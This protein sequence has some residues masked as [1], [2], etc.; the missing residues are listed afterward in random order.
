MTQSGYA[1]PREA[2]E[3]FPSITPEM[4]AGSPME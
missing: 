3:T 2:I 1:V 4:F